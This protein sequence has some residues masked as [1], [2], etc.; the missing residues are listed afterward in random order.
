MDLQLIVPEAA[1][2]VWLETKQ[3]VSSNFKHVRKIV[4]GNWGH[5]QNLFDYHNN[6][7]MTDINIILFSHLFPLDFLENLL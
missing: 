6:L 2:G 1:I 5:Q 7:S 3:M 4:Q